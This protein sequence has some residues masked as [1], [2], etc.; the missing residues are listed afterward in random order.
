MFLAKIRKLPESV[1]DS[2]DSPFAVLFLKPTTIKFILR[3]VSLQHST[4]CS[5]DDIFSRVLIH[6][7]ILYVY[8]YIRVCVGSNTISGFS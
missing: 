1:S 5:H 7:H 3:F 8:T 2:K 4:F 6:T